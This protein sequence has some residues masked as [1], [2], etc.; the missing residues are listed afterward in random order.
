MQIELCCQFV[1]LTKTVFLTDICILNVPSILNL[2]V[3]SELPNPLIWSQ[4]IN[5]NHQCAS[6]VFFAKN[7]VQKA[8]QKGSIQNQDAVNGTNEFAVPEFLETDDEQQNDV[9]D[10]FQWI[11]LTNF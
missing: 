4:T 8:I 9:G 6:N 3:L 5:F 2:V 7:Y 1:F 11:H 10:R